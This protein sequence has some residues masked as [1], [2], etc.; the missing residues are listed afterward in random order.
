MAVVRRRVHRPGFDSLNGV[1]GRV[2]GRAPQP[3]RAELA[4]PAVAPAAPPSAA[5][6]GK[7]LV[8]SMGDDANIGR[9][10]QL[11]NSEIGADRKVLSLSADP[12]YVTDGGMPNLYGVFGTRWNT[13]TNPDSLN[14]AAPVFQGIDWSGE[15]ALTSDNGKFDSS[16]GLVFANIGIQAV[17]GSPLASVSNSKFYDVGVTGP[18]GPD[19]AI[20]NGVSTGNNFTTL[21]NDLSAWKTFILGLSAETS[22]TDQSSWTNNSASNGNGGLRTTYGDALDTNSDGIIVVDISIG[23]NDFSVNNTDW[24]IDGTGNKLIIFRLRNGSNMLISNGSIL[25]GTGGIASRGLGALFFSAYDGNTSDAVFSFSNVVAS[26]VG[27]WDLNAVGEGG[28]NV[29]TNIVINN[30]QGCAQFISQKVNFQNNRWNRCAMAAAVADLEIIKSANPTSAGVGQNLTYTLLVTNT[31]TGE[32]TGVVVKDTL[33]SDVSFVSAN[34]SQGT[35][36][37]HSSGEVTCNLGT[38][39]SGGTATITIVVTVNALPVGTV[40]GI[41]LGDQSDYLLFFA[42]ARTD[43]N[44]QGATKGFVGDAAVNGIQADER[45]SG[46]VPYAGMISTNDTTLDAWQDIVDQNAGQ[47]FA[48]TGQIARISNLETELNNAFTQINALSVSANYGGFGFNGVSSTSLDGLDTTDGVCQTFVANIT[49]ELQVSSQI[50]ITGDA[51]D[52][53]VL[54]WDSDANF[55]DGYE[56]QVKFQSGGA[57]VPHGGLK[58][59]NFIHVAG[60]IGSSGGGSTPAAPYPQGPRLNDGTGA[61]CTGCDDFSGGGFFTGYWLT[62]GSPDNP[63]DGTHLVPYG[64]SSSLSNGIFVGGWYSIN[65][66]FSMTSGTSGV[67]VSPPVGASCP[68]GELRNV[69]SVSGSGTDPDL[70]NNHDDICT[71]VTNDAPAI[72]V[73]KYVGASATG[74]WDDADSPTGQT[75]TAGSNV[76]FRFVVTNTGNVALSNVTLSD[77]DFSPLTGC[78]VS[79]TLAAGQAYQCVYGPVTAITGQHENE[80]TAT[81]SYNG[82]TYSDT[83]L[84]HYLGQALDFGDAPDPTYPTLLASNGARHIIVPGGP[85]LNLGT[86]D[87]ETDGQPNTTASGDDIAGIDDEDGVSLPV[88]EP[89]AQALIGLSNNGNGFLNAWID[90][91]A[92]GDWGDPGEQI[93][94][95]VNLTGGASVFPIT[96]PADAEPGVTYAR[97]R[98]STQTGLLPTGLAPDGEVE[99]Y[100]VAISANGA[101]GDFVWYDANHDGVQDVGEPGIA[102]VTLDLYR[103]GVKFASTVTDADGGYIFKGLPP[104]DYSV[105]VTDAY[106]RLFDSHGAPF[107]HSTGNQ[108]QPDP[109]PSFTLMAGE[110]YKDADFGY[111]RAPASGNAIDR[112]HGV[113]RRQ[114]RRHP[115]ARRAWHPR[116]DGGGAAKQ[117]RPA[118]SGDRQQRSLPG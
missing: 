100:E 74:A 19:L 27:F 38:I 51:C 44:W 39:A 1:A 95:D 108:S 8:I 105:D 86:P 117:C 23:N 61:L 112:R 98:F 58:P 85:S 63:A 14:N 81:G 82:T 111:Y 110:V 25:M 69:A 12:G 15:V 103:N 60:D 24:V 48:S 77:S 54:R 43:A 84:A 101:I 107:S 46:G 109:T 80:A 18:N 62:T 10:F 65:T 56:G 32:A 114:R 113:V 87:S 37:S 92:D 67:Y 21:L 59:S 9:A 49:S 26:G 76:Y 55:V 29:N 91:N 50:N 35:G 45:T 34:A 20:G 75:Y 31:G 22:I 64:N 7:Y 73:E 2:A 47:A 93:A 102:N 106:L 3:G 71:P 40:G 96:V 66:S 17:N 88:L 70:T 79:G 11:S 90:F 42:D 94:T 16:Q 72:D 4:L 57:I 28:G 30:G 53:F 97:F 83:D 5:E 41:K 116:S 115:A 118:L 104:G 36:C 6:V 68:S 89:G 13:S 78:N 52:V 99:D 33:P